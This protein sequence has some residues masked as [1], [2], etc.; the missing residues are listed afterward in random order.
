MPHHVDLPRLVPLQP[1]PLEMIVDMFV[2]TVQDEE[3]WLASCHYSWPFTTVAE[4]DASSANCSHLPQVY[5]SA[6]LLSAL[7]LLEKSR[8]IWHDMPRALLK[9]AGGDQQG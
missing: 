8:L 7:S 3:A 6:R 9:V 1:V 5:S 4:R 2:K